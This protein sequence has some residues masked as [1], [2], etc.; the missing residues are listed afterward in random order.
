M[1]ELAGSVVPRRADRV[2]QAQ[3]DGELVLLSPKDFAY[4]GAL[5]TGEPVWELIDGVRSLDAIV[6]ELEA[7]YEAPPG[8]IRAQCA[9]FVD[10]LAAAGLV[11]LVA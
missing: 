5:G 4:F 2:V 6:A 7:G 10:A 3:V 1:A 9:E 8:V 11:T